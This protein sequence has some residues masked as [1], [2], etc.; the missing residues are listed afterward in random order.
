MQIRALTG[1]S[2]NTIRQ[3]GRS[4]SPL[5]GYGSNCTSLGSPRAI[6]STQPYTTFTSIPAQTVQ[7]K[8]P[9][10]GKTTF[11]TAD[12]MNALT[13]LLQQGYQLVSSLRGGSG[14]QTINVPTPPPSPGISKELLIGVGAL[15]L[16]FI[17]MNRK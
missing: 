10:T 15:A 11:F 13:A 1:F 5:N 2:E 9:K 4:Y 17:M 6:G 12:N 14:S 8:D 16:I 3:Y 7:V